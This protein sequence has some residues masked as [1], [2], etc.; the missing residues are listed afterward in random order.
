MISATQIGLLLLA[1]AMYVAGGVGAIAQLAG[2]KVLPTF[3]YLCMS[4]GTL[5]ALG[6]LVWHSITVVQATGAWQP[7]QDNLSAMLTLAILLAVFVLY[8]QLQGKIAAIEWLIMPVVILLLLMAGHFGKTQPHPYLTT[9]YSL[10]HRMTTFMGSVAFVVAGASGALYLKSDRMLRQRGASHLT[11]P[12]PGRFG[13]LERLERLSYRMATC[14]LALFTIGII[15]GVAW[16]IAGNG[17]TRL[18]LHWFLS[19]KVILAFAAWLIF[20]VVLH[21]PMAP[22]L[23]GRK[24]AILS[25]IGLL[26][27]LA[28]LLATLLMPTGRA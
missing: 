11:P 9:T 10:V 1:V 5:V 16:A 19:P 13:S 26:V 2:R 18:G 14:G 3:R 25:I 28:A 6:L 12:N 20:A 23:R 22:R 27:A 8:V 17:H 15:T 4:G 21:S 24:N 7:L